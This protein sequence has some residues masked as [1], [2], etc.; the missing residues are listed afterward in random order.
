MTNNKNDFK[1]DRFTGYSIIL[2]ERGIKELA[3]SEKF[4]NYSFSTMTE[5]LFYFYCSLYAIKKY[6]KT[7][8]EFVYELDDEKDALN[9][10]IKDYS[11]YLK[12]QEQFINRETGKKKLKK[13]QD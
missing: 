11:I 3:G 13:V 2:W 10:F 7:F 12:N 5:M 6:E 9:T 4:F 8:E 1:V